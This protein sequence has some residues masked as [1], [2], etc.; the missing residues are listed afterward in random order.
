MRDLLDVYC[1]DKDRHY[2]EENTL[3][4]KLKN[5]LRDRLDFDND[6]YNTVELNK[7]IRLNRFKDL[8]PDND[9]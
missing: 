2:G 5:K 6:K 3:L 7:M 8:I 9:P 1:M 4:S